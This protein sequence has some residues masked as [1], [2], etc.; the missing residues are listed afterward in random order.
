MSKLRKQNNN[1]YFLFTWTEHNENEKDV[2]T[3]MSLCVCVNM[4]K[5]FFVQDSSISTAPLANPT[6][7]LLRIF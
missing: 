1:H 3:D 5:N 4:K 2:V 6:L 7:L